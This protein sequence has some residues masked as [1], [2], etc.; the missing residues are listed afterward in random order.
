MPPGLA[1]SLATLPLRVGDWSGEKLHLD[2]EIAR[3]NKE[4]GQVYLK[5]TI[6]KEGNI[7]KAEIIKEDKEYFNKE[8]MRVLKLSPKW[9][10]GRKDG[11]LINVTITIPI[12]FKIH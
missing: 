3:Q 9:I 2:P 8:V 10:P 11:K 5:F 7:I 6:D 1:D 4:E 12:S